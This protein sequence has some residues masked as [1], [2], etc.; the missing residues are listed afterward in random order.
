MLVSHA[1]LFATL[2][3]VAL[4]APLTMG[5]ARQ[6]Y[7]SEL[8]CPPPGDLLNPGIEPTC[9]AS[10]YKQADYLAL[11]HQESPPKDYFFHYDR[12]DA[13]KERQENSYI[14]PVKAS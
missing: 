6:E 7:W 2:W 9:P 4:Q 13:G 3:T 10:P 12:E 11:S 5:F 1:Q 14:M 8:P